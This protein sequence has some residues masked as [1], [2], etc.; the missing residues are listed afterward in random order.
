MGG[1][2]SGPAATVS[3]NFM[4][5]VKEL[6]SSKGGGSINDL[7]AKLGKVWE[8]AKQ[9]V[10]SL[11]AKIANMICDFFMKDSAEEE[12]GDT[13]GY[14][15]GMIAFQALLEY[16]TA[17]TWDGVMAVLQSIAKFL[18]WPMEFLGEAMGLMKEL[19]GFLL[20]GIKDLGAMAAEGAG[21]ALR[22]VTGALGDIGTKLE[23]FADE[24]LG[25]LGG[26]AKAETEAVESD[27]AHAAEGDVVKAEEEGE[28]SA[29]E[30][31][32]EKAEE[33]VEAEAVIQGIKR[34]AAAG[35]VPGPALV[36]ALD[37]LKER[38]SWIE[39]F[40]P[41][42]QPAPFELMMYASEHDEG[43]YDPGTIPGELPKP[44]GEP[45]ASEPKPES[46]PTTKPP[47]QIRAELKDLGLSGG[48]AE[49]LLNGGG[50]AHELP[51]AG[52]GDAT[53]IGM[54]LEGGQ[55][56]SGI[57]SIKNTSGNALR[58]FAQ[59]RGYSRNVAR[60]LGASE[61]ELF[62]G[63]I[64]N[65]EIQAML[66]RLGFVPRT[67]AVPDALGGG[68]MEVLAKVFSV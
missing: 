63:A 35:H 47:E 14:M 44:E 34:A 33:L 31:E 62:G 51:S 19:G 10:S 56:S 61:M 66:T 5:A 57:I 25:K 41:V 21:G 30:R 32:A 67:V 18:N 1:E 22:E 64:I 28:L 40:G 4:P 65:P 54:K 27:L 6:F 3:S 38:Y 68:V 12:L 2:L 23:E 15:V 58:D 55:L 16:L 13:V 42:G 11:G 39:G 37:A 60:A 52:G 17:G 26:E 48:Q 59:F 53:I 36:L 20:D 50:I 7:M 9:A 46:E 43:R 29:A 24:L 8:A 49:E 45:P